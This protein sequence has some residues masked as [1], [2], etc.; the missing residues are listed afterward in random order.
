MRV[1]VRRLPQ[2]R[3]SEQQQGYARAVQ[4]LDVTPITQAI[5]GF[6]DQLQAEQFDRQKFDANKRFMDEINELQ[7][8]FE[9]R[10]RDPEIS[11]IDF[12]DT[13]N[14]AYKERHQVLLE[15]LRGEGFDRE[16]I[17]DLDLRLGTVRQGFY[18]K[19]L[20]HQLV[21][22]KGRALKGADDLVTS[23]S[24]YTATDYNNYLSSES[25]LRES[26]A[27]MP[28]LLEVEKE[29]KI[30]EGLGVLR[31]AGGKAMAIQ[32]PQLVIEKLDPMGLTA[33][34]RTTAGAT[35]AISLQNLDADRGTV[36]STLS[37]GGLSAPV[38][39][40]FLGNFDVE[41]GYEGAQ[42]DGGT[43]SGIAQWRKERRDNFKKMFGKDPH[44][45]TK[46][47][48]AQFVLWELANPG[49]AGMTQEQVAAI[50][51]A[52]TAEDAAELI[53][54]FYERSDGKH[55]SRRLEAAA[56]YAEVSP[57][58]ESETAG[59]PALAPTAVASVEIGIPILDAMNGPERLQ[60][61]AMAR[62]QLNKVSASRKAEM[63]V[64]IGNITA[65]ALNNGGEI[66]TPIPSDDDILSVYGPVQGPQVIAQIRQTKDTGKAIVAFRTRSA[67]DIQASLDAI[68]PRPGSP[69]YETEL[70]I[71]QAAERAAGQL[72]QERQS[73]PAAYAMKYFPSVAAATKRSTAHYYAELDR[74]YE[75]LGID[76]N[77]AP[78]LSS[79]ASR[80]I[81]DDYKR[82]SPYQRR[83]FMQENFIGMGEDRFRRFVSNMEGTTAQDDARIFA[84]LKTYPGA[85]G[86]VANVYQQVLEGREIMAK[87]PA[88]RPSSEK[89][90]EQFRAE[91][92]SAITNLN[93]DA[94]SAIQ[95]SAVA[96][97]VARGGNPDPMK[98][99]QMLYR[100]SLKMA[101]GGS[102]P[103]N[104][105][106]GDVKD[107]TI[108]P[109]RINQTQFQQ[110]TERQTFE[111]LTALS[112]E[113]RPPRYGDLKTLVQT[114]DLVDEGV[115]VMV[116]PG[117]YM[118]KMASD[119]QPVMTSTGRPFLVNIH[120]RDIAR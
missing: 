114:A 120:A 10:R 31:D 2:T 36:A 69:T 21:T 7:S 79:E 45:A 43:A 103:A 67:Q 93:A 17:E 72:L 96:L 24:Q 14:A 80:Q 5:E 1:P 84:L 22:L 12:A 64:T 105:R 6:R 73:D 106:K 74:V 56:K 15:E 91:G 70:Q 97:Y 110:W 34:R 48:Q 20:G 30:E 46:E 87:D 95:E 44:R 77:R 18:E 83:E 4:P 53:D 29:A 63:D 119:G 76:S 33:P 118:I 98:F 40:G 47:E 57:A 60:V 23:V 51:N 108:L 94:S 16:I 58:P 55:R 89:I 78:L 3:I 107:F 113:K 88:R 49:A 117:R 86:E 35:T 37:A 92:L 112:V 38:V 25:M 104:M 52:E 42:G 116:S 85:P 59:T 9:E 54:R 68:K 100:E 90:N 81:V 61:L 8:D 32:A 115:F 27:S 75:T 19:G 101:L 13:T 71:Y 50:K 11:P 26:I 99:D 66:A 65:E 109:P 111:S 82:M 62:E 41:A 28:D 102:L 39:A